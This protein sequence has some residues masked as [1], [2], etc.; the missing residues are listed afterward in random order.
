MWAQALDN[1]SPDEIEV[2]GDDL[3]R[4]DVVAH[5]YRVIEVGKRIHA[6]NNVKLISHRDQSVLEVISTVRDQAGRSAPIVCYVRHETSLTNST[7]SELAIS[8]A[9]FGA[10]IGRDLPEGYD[11]EIA[12]AINALKK[13]SRTKLTRTLVVVT[14]AGAALA[15]LAYETYSA[16]QSASSLNSGAAAY[17]EQ[18]AASYSRN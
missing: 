12:R 14:L 8:F 2:P 7:A 18:N 16:K 6:S 10:K 13:N 9:Q 1:T 17:E 3:T 11:V 15:V 4:E 5:V